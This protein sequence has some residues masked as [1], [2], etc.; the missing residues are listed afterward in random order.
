MPADYRIDTQQG[1]VFA[2]VRGD[3]TAEEVVPLESN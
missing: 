2:T 3:L 1:V